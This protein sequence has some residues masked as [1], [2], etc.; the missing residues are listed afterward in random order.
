MDSWRLQ[1]GVALI[2]VT[3]VG[4]ISWLVPHPAVPVAIAMVPI[5][6]ILAFRA[7]FLLCLLFI[8][9][10]FF[11]LHEA[12]PV[13]NP[14]RLPQL[15]AVGSL[16]VLGALVVTQRIRIAYIV[17]DD[18]RRFQSVAQRLPGAVEPVR[19][20]ESYLSNFR[21]LVGR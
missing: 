10:T 1:L 21:F 15:L 2:S 20:Y 4:L 3:V 16:V 18:D 14:L 13:L 9:F 6:G 8:L 19:L 12:F 7:P 17:T 5:A 11:R